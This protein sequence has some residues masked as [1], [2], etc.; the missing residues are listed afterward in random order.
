MYTKQ[1]NPIE[2]V[3]I[4]HMNKQYAKKTQIKCTWNI[5]ITKFVKI[6]IYDYNCLK[7]GINLKFYR[8]ILSYILITRYGKFVKFL[9]I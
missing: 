5:L 3:R 4:S 1:Y 6:I 8:V 7:I 9:I 2:F